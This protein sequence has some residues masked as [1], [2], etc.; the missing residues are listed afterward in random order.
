VKERVEAY[1]ASRGS[2]FGFLG[3]YHELKKQFVAETKFDLK[4]CRTRK[5]A[6]IYREDLDTGEV[7]EL[8]SSGPVPKGAAFWTVIP[9]AAAGE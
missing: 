5:Y 4:V 2:D 6:I 8:T 3:N 7:S 1:F 9:A